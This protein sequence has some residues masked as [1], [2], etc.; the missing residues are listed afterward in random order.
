MRLKHRVLFILCSALLLP[1]MTSAATLY[2]DPSTERYGPGDTFVLTIRIDNQKEC[3]NAAQV[4][5]TYPTDSLRAVD[6]GRGGSVLSLWT[7]EPKIDDTKGVVTF[8]GGIPG[9]YCGKIQGDPGESN[10]LGKVV[11]T[12][13]KADAG[14]AT[15]H[16]DPSSLVYLNDGLGTKAKLVTKD[17]HVALVHTPVGSSDV[18]V[19]EVG[20]DTTPPDSFTTLIESTRD[21]FGGLY[22]IVFSTVDKQS[23]IDH[24]E[25]F[26]NGDWKRVTSPYKLPDQSLKNDIRVKAIDKAGNERVGLYAGGVIPPS[27]SPHTS[28]SMVLLW[29]ITGC[30]VIVI[31]VTVYALLLRKKHLVDTTTAHEQDQM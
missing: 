9:G 14:T 27:Q 31:G 10:V 24:Y 15:I 16:L 6:F 7:E 22:Y 18:W 11:F 21:V 5:I 13:L 25:I 4:E 12:V 26:E 20:A 8:S 19:K 1:A 2:L 30:I 23:G 28:Y 17:A 29:G 3:V